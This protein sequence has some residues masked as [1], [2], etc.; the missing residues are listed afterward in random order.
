M[1]IKTFSTESRDLVH[2]KYSMSVCTPMPGLPW[3]L[4]GKESACQCRRCG[5]DRWIG[6]FLWRRKWPPTPVFL[7]G[8]SHGQRSLVGCSPWGCKGLDTTERLNNN[9]NLDL[10]GRELRSLFPQC[11]K[12][13][14]CA[15]QCISLPSPFLIWDWWKGLAD[16]GKL[17]EQECLLKW[18]F[19]CCLDLFLQMPSSWYFDLF[20][21]NGRSESLHIRCVDWEKRVLLLPGLL[22]GYSRGKFR[23]SL[24]GSWAIAKS[25]TVLAVIFMLLSLC[26]LNSSVDGRAMWP[27]GT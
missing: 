1:C 13:S 17:L 20:W 25:E 15:L 3:W 19:D 26:F 22:S 14:I 16:P 11:Q 10:K 7:P 24:H 9:N 8:D 6:R 5:F 4:S 23:D 21:S 2:L 27:P 12:L 18:I